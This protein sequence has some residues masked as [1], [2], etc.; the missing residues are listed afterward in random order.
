MCGINSWR[1]QIIDKCSTNQMK[2]REGYW[3]HELSTLSPV[4]LNVRDEGGPSR[5][6]GDADIVR[7]V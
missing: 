3:M 2:S 6:G 1:I 5:G 7:R 4:C